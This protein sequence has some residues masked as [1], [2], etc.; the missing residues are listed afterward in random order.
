MVEW[1]NAYYMDVPMESS[2]RKGIIEFWKSFFEKYLLEED[3][4]EKQQQQDEM[5]D[6]EQ[7][8][9]KE[10][11]EMKDK[12]QEEA[13]SEKIDKINKLVKNELMDQR[14]KTG[15]YKDKVFELLMENKEK[16]LTVE[17]LRKIQIDIE[18][19]TMS[20]DEE[21]TYKFY[22]HIVT[23][24]I[25]KAELNAKDYLKSLK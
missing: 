24:F 15:I 7:E 4:K 16:K 17:D 6:K 9:M 25:N 10:H 12:E 22:K 13:D 1:L 3:K 23:I 8:E 18:N 5:K 11:E 2:L 21:S 20:Y 14:T 19:M